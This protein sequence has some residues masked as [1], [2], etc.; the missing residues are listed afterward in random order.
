MKP[1]PFWRDY[2]VTLT[3]T[4]DAKEFRA[5]GA[6][7]ACRETSGDV[8]LSVGGNPDQTISRGEQMG[9]DS[10]QSL[11]FRFSPAP[12]VSFPLRAVFRIG[13]GDY[14]DTRLNIASGTSIKTTGANSLSGLAAQTVV[15]LAAPAS[16]LAANSSRKVARI[17]NASVASQIFV[18]TSSAELVAGNGELL[19]PDDILETSVQSEIFA[20]SGAG[21]IVRVSVE[22][23]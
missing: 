17:R 20:Y 8:V 19:E 11:L 16:I 3:G 12:G 15:A 4:N 23:Y 7:L 13:S 1:F 6:W 22:N 21:G 10:E 18:S 14:R 5:F 2:G 9:W